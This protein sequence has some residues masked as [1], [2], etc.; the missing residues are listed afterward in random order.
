MRCDQA[1]AHCGS[2]AAQ[3][4]PQELETPALLEVARA[5]IDLGCRE[6]A[7]IGGEAYLHP[8]VYELTEFLSA[9]DVRVITQTGGR[10]L[11]RSRVTLWHKKVR[12]LPDRQILGGFWMRFVDV[13]EP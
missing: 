2:R 11:T 4:R 1:C 8:G 7:L 3:A 10:G 9:R 6:V 5:L 13:V 12:A